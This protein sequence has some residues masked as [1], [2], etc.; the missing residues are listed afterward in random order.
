M[1]VK[2]TLAWA[3]VKI[4]VEADTEWDLLMFAANALTLAKKIKMGHPV[5]DFDTKKDV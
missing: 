3:Q 5:I 1:K 4:E 2:V